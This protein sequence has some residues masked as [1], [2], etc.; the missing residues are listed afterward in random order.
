[1]HRLKFI[2]NEFNLKEIPNLYNLKELTIMYYNNI[3][4]IH[5]TFNKI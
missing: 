3:T 1:M 5:I 2:Q 4:Q